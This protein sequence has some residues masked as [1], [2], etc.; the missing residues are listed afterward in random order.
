M[1]KLTTSSPTG[2]ALTFGEG[3]LLWSLTASTVT[4]RFSIAKHLY[5][6]HM[7]RNSVCTRGMNGQTSDTGGP[8]DE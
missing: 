6:C 4:V 8:I 5:A 7:L 3:S 2:F 1:K